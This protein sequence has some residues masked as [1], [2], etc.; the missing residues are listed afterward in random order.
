VLALTARAAEDS[1][2]V[3]AELSGGDGAPVADFGQASCENGGNSKDTNNLL[4][5]AFGGRDA[6][7]RAY[8]S[9]L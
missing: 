7:I 5:A 8:R 9:F 2:R 3:V 4:V 6:T 1:I